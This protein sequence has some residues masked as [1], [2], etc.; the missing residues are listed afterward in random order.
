MKAAP[1]FAAIFTNSSSRALH[2]VTTPKVRVGVEP[3]KLRGFSCKVGFRRYLAVRR[4]IGEGP[5]S[6]R[7]GNTVDVGEWPQFAAYHPFLRLVIA[8]ETY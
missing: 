1:R 4:R 8:F 6:T 2:A 5:E 3:G 7:L